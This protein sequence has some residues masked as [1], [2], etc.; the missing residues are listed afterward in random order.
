MVAS[1]GARRS[2]VC[3]E[4]LTEGRRAVRSTR[5]APSQARP[6]QTSPCL[7]SKHDAV[8]AIWRPPIVLHSSQPN[9]GPLIICSNLQRPKISNLE[10]K[11]LTPVVL[12]LALARPSGPTI[13]VS[14]ANAPRSGRHHIAFRRP[15]WLE[16]AASV[17]VTAAATAATG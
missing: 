13:G 16:E 11:R 3:P 15:F 10:L 4:C 12:A 17:A 14:R 1:N 8:I 2:L 6:G 5:R 9:V 7:A